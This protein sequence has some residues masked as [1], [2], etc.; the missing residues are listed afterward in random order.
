MEKPCLEIFFEE[1]WKG[2]AMGDTEPSC[3]TFPLRMRF[4]WEQRWEPLYLANG[5]STELTE[6]DP[7]SHASKVSK[8]PTVLMIL[9]IQQSGLQA[10]PPLRIAHLIFP[11]TLLK[12]DTCLHFYTRGLSLREGGAWPALLRDRAK[13]LSWDSLAQSQ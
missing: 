10:R 7:P 11:T 4:P 1:V 6:V 8:M 13:S 2:K 9:A 3:T 12:R 5:G